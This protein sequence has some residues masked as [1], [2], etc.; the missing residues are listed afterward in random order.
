M[1]HADDEK[2]Q[3]APEFI[4]AGIEDGE[5]TYYCYIY[6]RPEQG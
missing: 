4:A 3:D 6:A 2:P 5:T 1:A